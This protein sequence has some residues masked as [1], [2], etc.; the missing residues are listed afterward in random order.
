MFFRERGLPDT[1]ITQRF[2]NRS[3]SGRTALWRVPEVTDHTLCDKQV[4]YAY[5]ADRFSVAVTIILILK[6]TAIS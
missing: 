1:N 5:A 2:T 3:P 4:A 6:E